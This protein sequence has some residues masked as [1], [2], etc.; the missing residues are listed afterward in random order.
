MADMNELVKFKV[1]GVEQE[2]PLH[3]W[4]A[5]ATKAEGAD[6]RFREAA[7]LEKQ[8]ETLK[9]QAEEAGTYKKLLKAAGNGDPQAFLKIGTEMGMEYETV[10]QFWDMMNGEAGETEVT[11]KTTQTGQAAGPPSKIS[12]SQLPDEV[13]AALRY[14]GRMAQT[15][16]D[17]ADHLQIA[18][19]DLETRGEQSARTKIGR[20]LDSHPLLRTISRQK[21]ARTAL[22]ERIYSDLQGRVDRG[23]PFTKALD[24]AVGDHA[25]LVQS[26]AEALTEQHRTLSP[27]IFGFGAGP[28]GNRGFSLQ[29]PQQPKLDGQK[30]LDKGGIASLT[31]S[32]LAHERWNEANGGN[33]SDDDSGI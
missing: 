24:G 19:R 21:G 26:T 7:E 32:L 27:E 23:E 5:L 2:R 29:A 20:V 4:L 12:L 11:P 1:A 6:A 30:V 15:G 28:A 18:S 31:D 13:V 14:V 22:I 16:V 10:S 8:F 9:A 33:T 25:T 3:E 17:P